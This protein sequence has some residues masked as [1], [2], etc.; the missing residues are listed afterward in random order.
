MRVYL[1]DSVRV[2]INFRYIFFFINQKSD[3]ENKMMVNNTCSF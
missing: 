3:R 2:Y 1:C